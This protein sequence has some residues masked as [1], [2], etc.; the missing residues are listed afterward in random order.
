M[1]FRDTDGRSFT[2]YEGAWSLVEGNGTTTVSY[3]LRADPSFA[4]PDLLL[5]R[6]L[7]RDAKEMIERLIDEI[8]ARRSAC[9]VRGRV[10]SG[11][12]MMS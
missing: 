1:S 5:K 8:T 2:R 3:E 6:L 10:C 11:S 9:M 7:K 4:V 12:V